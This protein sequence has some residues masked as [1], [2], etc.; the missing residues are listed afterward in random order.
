MSI[1]KKL[2]GTLPDGKE[3]YAYSMTGVSGLIATVMDMGGTVLELKTP[4]RFGRLT[5]VV[6]GYDSLSDYMEAGGYLGALIGRW[7]NRI[8]KAKFS[9]DGKS[10]SLYQ[11][12]GNNHLHGGKVGFSHRIWTVESAVDGD[13]PK[14]ILSLISPDGE[15][16]YPGT[17]HVRVTYAVT[18]DNALS[19]HYEATTDQ[20]TVLN[21]TN[22]TYFNLGGYASGNV[23]AEELWMDADRYL[24]TDAELIPT[25]ERVPV[26]GTPFDFRQAK[27]IGRDFSL[28][29]EDMRL[30][31][32]YD[33]CFCFT[34]GDEKNLVHRVT[35]Y[36]PASGR[37]MKVI[38]DQPCVQLYTANF[39]NDEKHPL[40]GGYPQ[41]KQNAF[42]LETQHMPD[43]MN[44]ADFTDCT[45]HPGEKYDYTTIYQFSVR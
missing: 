24:R 12:D 34:N 45:L 17:L 29:D 6:C 7:G 37:E 23:F 19:I 30:A 35:A 31:G 8:G 10:Y 11:N 41:G 13:E 40:K 3:V 4:D 28:D 9:L 39:L 22:H 44:H 27:S 1:T 2:F 5:D 15:E 36:D 33:H 16:G 42:C 26:S 21:L 20:T 25:G 38:T 32:G 14:L 43:S 18:K